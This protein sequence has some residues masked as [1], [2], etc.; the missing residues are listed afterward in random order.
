MKKQLVSLIFISISVLTIQAASSKLVL[1]SPNGKLAIEAELNAKGQPVYNV[2]LNNK[3]VIMQSSLG[4]ITDKTDFTK[5]VS[6]GSI[7]KVTKLQETYSAP[8]E[9]RATRTYT[10][11]CASLKLTNANKTTLN[12]E[13]KA[14]NEGVAFRYL[15]SDKNPIAVKSE[16]TSFKFPTTAKA[17]LHPHANV[18]EGWCGTQPSYEEQYEYEIPVGTKSPQVAGW[19][20]P[21]LFHSAENW[22]LIT[23]AGLTP[24]YVGTRLAQQ[25]PNGEY[26]IG[27]PQKG[28][29]THPSDPEIGRAHV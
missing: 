15:T 19:S 9:K 23:E 13:F 16:Q 29:T 10:A 25:S 26:G 24:N 8:A 28:E 17:W 2:K 14:T 5:D 6:I 7:S 21:A 11:N 3:V 12:V 27:F 22:V 18:K 1:K 4:L 20:F